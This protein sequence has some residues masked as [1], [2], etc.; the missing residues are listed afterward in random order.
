M[1]GF[2][3]GDVNVGPDFNRMRREV[4]FGVVDTDS[5]TEVQIITPLKDFVSKHR[6][7][8]AHIPFSTL[9]PSCRKDFYGRAGEYYIDHGGSRVT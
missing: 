6:N 1:L 3:R 8:K 2:M 4:N 7:V 5:T 9:N